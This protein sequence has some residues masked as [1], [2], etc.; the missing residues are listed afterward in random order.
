MMDSCVN[1]WL[2]DLVAKH[3]QCSILSFGDCRPALSCYWYSDQAMDGIKALAFTKRTCV[4]STAA[5]IIS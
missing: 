4:P 2:N 5:L 1:S 3:T